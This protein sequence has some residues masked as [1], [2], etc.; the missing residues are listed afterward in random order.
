MRILNFLA[1]KMTLLDHSKSVTLHAILR[2]VLYVP[3]IFG[4][5]VVAT[6]HS[7]AMISAAN[8]CMTIP[9]ILQ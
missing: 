2:D 1:F 4:P 7:S 6:Q 5:D 8:F 3:D 9:V